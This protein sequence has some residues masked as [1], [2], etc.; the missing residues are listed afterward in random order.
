[1]KSWDEMGIEAPE[2]EI[3][4]EFAPLVTQYKAMEHQ[5]LNRKIIKLNRPFSIAILNYQGVG[6]I[7]GWMTRN[8]TAIYI[9]RS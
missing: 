3:T 6:H 8:S 2:L 5:Q 4:W 1:M 7:G 9:A